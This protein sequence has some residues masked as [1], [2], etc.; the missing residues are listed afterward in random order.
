MDEET[1]KLFHRVAK[2]MGWTDDGLDTAEEKVCCQL[3]TE[4]MHKVLFFTI[5]PWITN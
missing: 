1:H 2:K 3:N 5:E 4:C